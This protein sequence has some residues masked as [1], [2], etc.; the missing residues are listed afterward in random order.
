M[1]DIPV[2]E[3]QSTLCRLWT[4]VRV[5][6]RVTD[7]IR[8]VDVFHGGSHRGQRGGEL[9]SRRL[10]QVRE[11]FPVLFSALITKPAMITLHG[12]NHILSE[13]QSVKIKKSQSFLSSL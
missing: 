6:S 8:A 5:R 3:S 7:L 11:R 2:C 1:W 4:A 10:L 9:S 12:F 13:Q